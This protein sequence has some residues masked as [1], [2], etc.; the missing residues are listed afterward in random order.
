MTTNTTI[1][2]LSALGTVSLHKLASAR[3]IVKVW[4][5]KILI[6]RFQM[7]LYIMSWDWGR[8]RQPWEPSLFQNP[9]V[10][11]RE[12]FNRESLSQFTTAAAVACRSMDLSSRPVFG[13]SNNGK[14][15]PAYGRISYMRTV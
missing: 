14:A 11:V 4:W 3:D 9:P 6:I 8:L 12:I 2:P 10:T 1:F 5:L 13:L 15:R 7:L